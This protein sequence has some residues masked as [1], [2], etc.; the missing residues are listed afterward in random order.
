MAAAFAS[1]LQEEKSLEG[2][3]GSSGTVSDID[4]RIINAGT[5]ND[6]LGIPGQSKINRKQA[7]KV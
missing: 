4:E 3:K 5:V 6:L 1:L 2:S 7:L